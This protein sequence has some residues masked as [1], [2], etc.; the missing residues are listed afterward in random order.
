MI[1]SLVTVSACGRTRSRRA[2]VPVV[3]VVSTDVATGAPSFHIVASV[4]SDWSNA[5]PP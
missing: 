4:V 1:E 5:C 2:A 3:D